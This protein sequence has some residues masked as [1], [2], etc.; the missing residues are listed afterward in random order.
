MTANTNINIIWEEYL[1][2]YFNIQIFATLW[3]SA[4]CKKCLVSVCISVS[5]VQLFSALYS[6]KHRKYN[7]VICCNKFGDIIHKLNVRVTRKHTEQ[8]M[9]QEEIL[10]RNSQTGKK[11]IVS[12]MKMSFV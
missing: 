3:S 12:W 1:L 4:V 6:G 9:M 11:T 5:P 7:S 8:K 2:I 10:K